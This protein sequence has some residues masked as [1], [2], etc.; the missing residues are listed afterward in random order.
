MNA[1]EQLRSILGVNGLLLG[2]RVAERAEGWSDTTKNCAALA[3]ARPRTVGEVSAT[4]ELCNK[5]HIG[6]VPYGGGTGLVRGA[7]AKPDQ[8]LLSL[9]RM[10]TI[11]IV[12]PINR[13]AVVEAGVTL[14]NLQEE[15]DRSGLMFPLDL[16]ARGSATIGGNISTNAGGNRVVRFGMMRDMVLG[17]E[18]VLA[19]GTI[20]TSMNQLI[21]NNTGYD[22]KQLFIGS[23]GTLGVVTRAVL[24]LREK[25]N[26]EN[27]ALIAVKNFADILHLLKVLDARFGGALSAFEV[28]WR[29]FY[30]VVTA[31][32]TGRNPPLPRGEPYYILIECLGADLVEDRKRFEDILMEITL[33]GRIS[34]AVLATS[35][36]QASNLWSIRDDVDRIMTL[37]PIL[38]FD[39]SLP[40]SSMED[41]VSDVRR[42]LKNLWP[43]HVCVVWGHLGDCNLHI[44][45]TVHLDDEHTRSKVEEIVYNPLSKIGGSISAEHGIGEEKIHY[46][47]V[48]RNSDEINL[49]KS[50]K[51]MLDP[52]NILNPGKIFC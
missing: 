34:D 23:E 43:D 49:M 21:K 4:L 37:G 16:G 15:V 5:N 39:V 38:M 29:E 31:P 51:K 35:Y 33:D 45:I 13:I 22:L 46:L 2:D 36:E 11:E 20:L 3:V 8:I 47:S 17:L 6:V 41:Y 18:V 28:M 27:A 10:R 40:I 12:D 50:I 48:S 30:D 19:N 9:E 25:C 32:G 7:V 26:S 42:S 1:L 14:Q 44:W 24:R 52:Y